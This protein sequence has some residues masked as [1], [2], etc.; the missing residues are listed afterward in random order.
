MKKYL[1]VGAVLCSSTLL[2]QTY[3]L[4]LN[5]VGSGTAGPTNLSLHF[6][7]FITG[8]GVLDGTQIVTTNQ[9]DGGDAHYSLI[10]WPKTQDT[11]RVSD[12]FHKVVI[13]VNRF[14][15]Q[16][17]V[18]VSNAKSGAILGRSSGTCELNAK[19]KF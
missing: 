2:A 6:A 4:S 9:M 17:T 18:I 5:C 16:F 19:P 12:I 15:G 8:E 13:T 1:L 14:N 11:G 3:P 7:N 10:G